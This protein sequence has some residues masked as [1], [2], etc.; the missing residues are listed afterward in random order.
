MSAT[1]LAD[2]AINA[3]AIAQLTQRPKVLLI[4]SHPALLGASGETPDATMHGESI[5]W[6]EAGATDW[7]A[8]SRLERCQD[9]LIA[10]VSRCGAA[11]G[12]SRG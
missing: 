5:A 11:H 8:K 9:A 3:A 7:R 12:A 10:W 2:A 4:E 1:A 6:Q